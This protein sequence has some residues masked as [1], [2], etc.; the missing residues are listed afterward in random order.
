[1]GGGKEC[2]DWGHSRGTSHVLGSVQKALS[3]SKVSE[4]S[5]SSSP[6]GSQMGAV[7][8]GGSKC[9]PPVM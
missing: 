8:E 5:S 3:P 4:G 6:G 7:E 1:M 2:R 9:G